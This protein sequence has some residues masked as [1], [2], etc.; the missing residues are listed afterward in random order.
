MTTI[1]R[2][3]AEDRKK[4]AKE[5]GQ[6][7]SGV[8]MQQFLAMLPSTESIY[9]MLDRKDI[10]STC[11]QAVAEVAHKLAVLN[12]KCLTTPVALYA[13]KWCLDIDPRVY[14]R[15]PTPNKDC[16]IGFEYKFEAPIDDA[17]P[18]TRQVFKH[19]RD[20]FTNFVEEC[21]GCGYFEE[22]EGILNRSLTSSDLCDWTSEWYRWPRQNDDKNSK[23]RHHN[24][25][26][27]T[28][29][30]VELPESCKNKETPELL[31]EAI[32]LHNAETTPAIIVYLR[33]Y[34]KQGESTYVYRSFFAN[35]EDAKCAKTTE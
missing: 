14:C 18:M 25:A 33:K 23:K 28:L 22:T 10:D 26:E 4:L 31:F 1:F 11:F 3:S 7:S 8:T 9:T 17:V 13:R 30:E 35:D 16:E 24:T 34:R 2:T 21:V 12:A 20:L 6:K 27:Y 19:V 29:V 32:A 5:R 15:D